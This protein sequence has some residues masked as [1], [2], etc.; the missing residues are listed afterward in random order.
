MKKEVARAV[1]FPHGQVNPLRLT[2]DTWLSV[3]G[4][5]APSGLLDDIA[6]QQGRWA[7]RPGEI[8]IDPH[9]LPFPAPI[10]AKVTVTSAPGKPELTVVGYASSIGPDEGAWVAP[11]Q[12][13]APA[14][15]APRSRCS[16]H[17]RPGGRH[18]GQPT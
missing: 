10:G 9:F 4:R 3:V 5:A 8:D 6:L 7:T 16:R 11:S 14:P 13:A 2:P 17:L 18:P 12:I 1:P 15:R